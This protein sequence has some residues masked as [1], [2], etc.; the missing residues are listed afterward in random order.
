MDDLAQPQP[1]TPEA[2]TE[3]VRLRQEVQHFRDEAAAMAQA[4]RGQYATA[5]YGPN[6]FHIQ[7]AGEAW[8]TD[9]LLPLTP[10]DAEALA[11]RQAEME[12]MRE[13]EQMALTRALSLLEEKLGVEAVAKIQ[14]GGGVSIRSVKWPNVLY[15]VPRDPHAMVKVLADGQVVT[16]VCIVSTDNSLPWPDILLHRVTAIE[17]DESILFARGVV[18]P[19]QLMP[20][21]RKLVRFFRNQG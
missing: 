10:V 19:R 21:W 5:W 4:Y 14:A 9:V 17:A 8:A 13:R 6:P 1:E 20:R 2:E 7:V 3:L 11:R 15:I 12:A 18:H 16:E